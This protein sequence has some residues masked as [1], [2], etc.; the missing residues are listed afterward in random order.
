[1]LRA[2]FA[3][4]TTVEDLRRELRAAIARGVRISRIA[5]ATG[6]HRV[7]I[8]NFGHARSGLC[9]KHAFALSAY[10]AGRPAPCRAGRGRRSTFSDISKR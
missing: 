6:I 5:E 8:S 2:T 9:A 10:L 3:R 7:T 1:M 4:M